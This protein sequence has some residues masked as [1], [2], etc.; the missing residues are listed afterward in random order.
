MFGIIHIFFD[1]FC[2]FGYAIAIITT[3]NRNSL[4]AS[5]SQWM[6]IAHYRLLP[7]S[8]YYSLFLLAS[9]SSGYYVYFFFRSFYCVPLLFSPNLSQ[10]ANYFSP[11]LCRKC[12]CMC[13]CSVLFAVWCFTKSSFVLISAKFS[14]YFHYESFC[15]L[16]HF[17]R[18]L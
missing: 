6:L 15:L 10:C 18:L 5:C 8:K 12:M 4:Q 13:K 9:I 3:A 1:F 11:Y 14:I 16:K 7:R 2:R 17:F